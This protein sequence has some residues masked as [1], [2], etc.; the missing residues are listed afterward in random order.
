MAAQNLPCRWLTRWLS[1][2]DVCRHIC[3]GISR[4]GRVIRRLWCWR[5]RLHREVLDRLGFNFQDL[6]LKLSGVQ[7]LPQNLKSVAYLPHGLTITAAEELFEQIFK[8]TGFRASPIR[9]FGSSRDAEEIPWL[10]GHQTAAPPLIQLQRHIPPSST[11]TS[12]SP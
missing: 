11:R 12:R 10:I 3:G 5:Q 9:P 6:S 1:G 8:S 4:S 2:G 7:K